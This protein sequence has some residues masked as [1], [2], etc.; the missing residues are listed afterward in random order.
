MVTS[1]GDVGPRRLQRARSTRPRGCGYLDLKPA[2]ARAGWFM[3]PF[4]TSTTARIAR[5]FE[6]GADA[7][8]PQIRRRRPCRRH[9]HRHAVRSAD[10]KRARHHSSAGDGFPG[11]ERG[12]RSRAAGHFLV[13]ARIM[14]IVPS[15]RE[16]PGRWRNSGARGRV[17]AHRFGFDRPEARSE[18]AASPP[19]RLA[20]VATAS[21]R[22]R[23]LVHR[24]RRSVLF[25][26]K[27]RLP[28]VVAGSPVPG[29]ACGL[30]RSC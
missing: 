30:P 23:G 6:R 18:P 16:H 5:A 26:H 1:R 13:E 10:Q 17:M 19:R 3:A 24:F 27:A 2:N 14:L 22:P 8:Y 9:R 25:E 28:V 12:A 7:Q 11:L 21:S 20:L 4:G 15:P 29:R